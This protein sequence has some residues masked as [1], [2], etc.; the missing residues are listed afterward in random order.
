MP[1]RE[2]EARTIKAAQKL[3]YFELFTRSINVMQDR[4]SEYSLEKHQPDLL[5]DISNDACGTFEFYRAKEMI[6]V[7]KEAFEN[8]LAKQLVL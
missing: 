3:S 4:I 7:G 6:A 2:T 5:I 8:A 1:A